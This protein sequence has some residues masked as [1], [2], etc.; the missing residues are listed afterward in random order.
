MTCPPITTSFTITDDDLCPFARI[1]NETLITDLERGAGYDVTFAPFSLH[2][3]SLRDGS[4]AVWDAD[5]DVPA[6]SGVLALLW[7]LAVR[8]T[9]PADFL[10]FHA[11]VFSARHDEGA[12]INDSDVLRTIVSGIGLDAD[13]IESVVLGGVPMKVLRDEHTRL[14]D[15]YAVFGVPTFIAGRE[16]VF[17]RLMQRHRSDDLRRVI[18]MLEW[19]DLNEFK[20]TRVDR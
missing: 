11:A 14:V 1:A 2:Q 7:S 9:I 20:R 16:A 8:D 10:A 19:S 4:P 5:P 12:D 6:G 13:A 18:D 17:V 3:N 15:E